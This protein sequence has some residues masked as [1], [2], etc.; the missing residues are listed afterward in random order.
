[1]PHGLPATALA[2]YE[3]PGHGKT[4]GASN[5]QPHWLRGVMRPDS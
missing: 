5:T 1:M 2:V 3:T 4:Q